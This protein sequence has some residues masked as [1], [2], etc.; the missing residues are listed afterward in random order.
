[1]LTLTGVFFLLSGALLAFY[2][3]PTLSNK[4]T[5]VIIRLYFC[6]A[7]FCSQTLDAIDGKVARM[8]NQCSPLGQL[9]DHSMDCFSN[10]FTLIMVTSSFSLGSSIH[11]IISLL[12]IQVKNNN[13]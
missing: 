13:K 5:T 7:I 11:T 2:N 8:R 1:M 6:L 3:D 12:H 9:M 4:H 10:S